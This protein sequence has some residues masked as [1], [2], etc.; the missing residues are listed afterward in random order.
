M[1]RRIL[2]IFTFAALTLLLS[3]TFASSALAQVPEPAGCRSAETCPGTDVCIKINSSGYGICGKCMTDDDCFK[4]GAPVKSGSGPKCSQQTGDC[5]GTG[6]ES[7]TESG[8]PCSTTND[9]AIGYKCD[10]PTSGSQGNCAAVQFGTRCDSA[11]DCGKDQVCNPSGCAEAPPPE[12]T[13]TTKPPEFKPIAP[14]LSIPIPNL[15]LS[16][17]SKI[18]TVDYKGETYVKIPYL[19]LYL[20][21]VYRLGIGVA[22]VLAVIMIMIGG[23]IWL[24]AAGDAGKIGVAKKMIT[25]AVVGLFLAVGSYTF[26]Q[27]VNPDLL[28]PGTFLIKTVRPDPLE[29]SNYDEET[30][31]ESDS[32]AYAASGVFCPQKGGSGQIPQ[33]VNSLLGKIYYRFGGHGQPPPY[34]KETN[35]K[36]Q[37]YKS[38]C[39][40]LCYDCSSFVKYVLACAGIPTPGGTTDSIFGGPGS[41]RITS[42]TPDN[43]INNQDLIPGDL[44]GWRGGETKSIGHVLMYVGNGIF[45]QVTSGPTG[46]EGREGDALKRKPIGDSKALVWVWWAPR[47]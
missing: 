35:Q 19:S 28:S 43:K 14:V 8:T 45:A 16:A 17:F 15:D 25:G 6:G 11:G 36:F 24:A 20:A 29:F 7:G 26:M 44:V 47:P 41:E 9:C 38:Y 46:I 10:I 5:V 1:K 22:G 37:K 13:T 23:F 32:G 12:G 2:I 34:T 3:S 39:P 18:T 21:A 30:G 31:E 40:G 27:I 33:I 4:N 42:F